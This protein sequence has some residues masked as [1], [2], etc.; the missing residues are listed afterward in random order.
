MATLGGGR[1]FV[2]S[3][4]SYVGPPF[5]F[6]EEAEDPNSQ[7]LPPTTTF[8]TAQFRGCYR[9]PT[10]SLKLASD[11]GISGSNDSRAR[12]LSQSSALRDEFLEIAY[13]ALTEEWNRPF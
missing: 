7:S 5:G 13:R 10:L 4:A 11:P 8:E 3:C 1:C 12:Q 2:G 9:K 6:P